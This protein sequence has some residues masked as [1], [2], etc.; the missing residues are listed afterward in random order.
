MEASERILAGLL[1]VER[2]LFASD[3]VCA[4]LFRCS[5]GHAMFGGGLPS[6][7]HCMVFP[8]TAVWIQHD[9]GRRFVADSSV[10]TLYNRNQA[11]RRWMISPE[12]DRSDW[13][14]FPADVILDTVAAVAPG[15]ANRLRHEAPFSAWSA[16]IGARLYATQRRLFTRLQGVTALDPLP[17][18]ELSLFLL[19]TVV[20]RSCSSPRPDAG[21]QARSAREAIEHVR[22]VLARH[23]GTRLSLRVLAAG[24]GWSACHLCRE[25]RRQCGTTLTAYR[26]QLR[27]RASLDRIAAG[28]D[29]MTIALDLG[30]T[31]H[32]HFT[33]AFRKTFG[34]VPSQAR[35]ALSIG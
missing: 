9:G 32:S 18:E 26:S 2:L 1:P 11:Y 33:S 35:R 4:G 21:T 13:L 6:T 34:G 15:N 31:S 8:R 16:P 3:L 10:V 7:A 29:L 22:E 24:V 12:G 20:R 30:F 28:E 23:P 27:L 14:A 17:V 19:E 25:F 5:P